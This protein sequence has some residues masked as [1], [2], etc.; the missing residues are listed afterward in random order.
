MGRMTNKSNAKLKIHLENDQLIMYGTSNESS[1]CVLRG[2]L[3]LRLKKPTSFKS[4]V[5]SFYGTMSVSWSQYY[6]VLGNGY[7]RKYSD[8]RTLINHKWTFLPLQ[9]HNKHHLLEAG[10]HSY[11]FELVLPGTLPESTHVAEYYIVQYQM[12]A[13]A[14]RSGFLQPNYTT[15]HE[16]HLSRQKLSLS[17]DY[18]DPVTVANHWP[19]KLDYEISLPTKVYNHGDIIPVTIQALPLAPNL[20]VRYISC[21]FKEYMTCRAI[22]GWFNGKNKS[23]GR[24]IHYTRRDQERQQQQNMWSTVMHIKVPESLT[25]IQCDAHN[26]SVRVR[27]KLK[28]VMSIENEDGHISELRAILPVV[29][30]ITN[31]IERLPA[32]EETGR[33]MPYD[34][35]LMMALIRRS[36]E[37]TIIDNQI[38]HLLPQRRHNEIIPRSSSSR[39]SGMLPSYSSLTTTVDVADSNGDSDEDDDGDEGEHYLGRSLPSYDEIY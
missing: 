6:S 5:L 19:D 31:S 29:I 7:E 12:K 26:D 2:A 3:S 24:I 23:H 13:V 8:H 32:Y 30:A 28:F 25:D 9:A 18:F 17:T 1:G 16:I 37:S 39:N 4:M 10:Y 22:N 34:P 14:E 20:Q 27:H 33:T 11:E 36:T 21:T 15:R 35:V 38:V